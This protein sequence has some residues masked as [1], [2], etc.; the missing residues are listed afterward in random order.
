MKVE[1]VEEKI[2][3]H[4]KNEL[5]KTYSE[6]ELEERFKTVF[7]NLNKRYELDLKGFFEIDVYQDENYGIIVEI[8]GPEDFYSYFNQ[9][10]MKI[11]FYQ[12]EFLYEVTN[13]IKNKYLTYYKNDDKLYIKIKNDIPKA[14]YFSLLEH[15]K[16]IY[17]NQK[18]KIEKNSEVVRI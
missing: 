7:A 14:N 1:F 4:L 8:I 3:V 16:I 13:F 9:V 18:D 11:T 5:F 10:E 17:G 12:C 6:A 2:V 15:A